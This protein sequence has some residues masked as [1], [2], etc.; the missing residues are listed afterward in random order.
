M[1]KKMKKMKN[2]NIITIFTYIF[3]IYTLKRCQTMRHYLL[4]GHNVILKSERLK[5]VF[6]SDAG[7]AMNELIIRCQ[8]IVAGKNKKCTIFFDGAPPGDL[9]TG[10][11]NIHVKFSYDRT[12]DALIKSLIARSKNPRNLIVISDD[13]EI[14][15]FARAHSCALET[16]RNFLNSAMQT[17]Q[18]EE[19]EKPSTDD[20]S[21]EEWL[22]IFNK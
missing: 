15:R 1:Y 10:S 22:R 12:A 5:S 3:G 17:G 11:N 4:D 19:Q 2:A 8:R 9:V 18:D 20:L 14:Q 13:A 21:I 6:S 16:V 7:R